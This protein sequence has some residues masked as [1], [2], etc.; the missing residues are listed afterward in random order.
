MS[1]RPSDELFARIVA[2][3]GLDTVAKVRL[4]TEF[5]DTFFDIKEG[6]ERL[7]ILMGVL[8]WTDK[9]LDKFAELVRIR[10]EGLIF[11]SIVEQP[12]KEE[13]A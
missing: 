2:E 12:D 11:R 3:M 9:E 7:R 1:D 4:C 5:A 10:R 13:E 6:I 8:G